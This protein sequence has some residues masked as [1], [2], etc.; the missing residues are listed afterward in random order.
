MNENWKS[1]IVRGISVAVYV[2]PDTGKFVHKSRPYH[3]LVLNDA[4]G[5]KDYIFDDGFVLHTEENSLFYLPKGSSYRVESIRSGGCYAINFDADIEDA[6]FSVTFRSTDTLL[7]HFKAACDEWRSKSDHS[8][9]L[10]MCA[11]YSGIY[12]MQKESQKQYVSGTQISLISPAIREIEQYFSEKELTVSSL[13]ELCG[14]SEAYFRRIFLN[15]FGV[16]PKE[17]IISKR[18]SYAARLIDSE[19]FSISDIA[20]MCGYDEIC[21][22]SREF[23]KKFGVSPR[24]YAKSSIG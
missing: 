12:H 22:F 1:I 4:V 18:L 3:G 6:P 9:S 8:N 5:A 23:K 2:A 14:I 19:Q 20:R 15:K 17:Y 13:A 24:E 16:S 21:H 11:L 7:H 10:A